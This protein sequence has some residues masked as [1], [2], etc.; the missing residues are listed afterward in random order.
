MIN[1]ITQLL[2]H[3]YSSHGNCFWCFNG[4][5]LLFLN[6]SSDQFEAFKSA[7]GDVAGDYK[8]KTISFLMGDLDASQGAFQVIS[9]LLFICFLY[10]N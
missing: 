6:F 5:A 4:Q 1:S 10:P 7:Y 3:T 9:Y 2:F 8:G